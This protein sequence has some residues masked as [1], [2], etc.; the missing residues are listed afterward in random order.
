VHFSKFSGIDFWSLDDFNLSNSNALDWVNGGDFLGN[1]LFNSFTGEK[2]E[3][4][5]SIGLSNLL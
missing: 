3:E 2:T 1:L 4:L 5:S